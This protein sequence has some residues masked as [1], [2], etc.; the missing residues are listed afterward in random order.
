MRTLQNTFK[1]VLAAFSFF[2]RLPFW[3]IA[4]IEKKHYERVVPLWSLVGWLTGG[5]M[6]VVYIAASACHLPISI[7]VLLSLISRVLVTGALHEDGFADFCDGFGGGRNRQRILEIMKDSH[8]GTYGVLGLVF[9]YLL[10]WN[11]MTEVFGAGTSPL[12]FVAVDAVCKYFSSTIIYFLPYARTE[13]EAKNKLVY[14]HTSIGKKI[15]SFV[16]GFLPISMFLATEPVLAFCLFAP[17]ICCALL[18]RW[19]HHRIQGYTGDCC[20][21]TFIITESIFYLSLCV[22]LFLK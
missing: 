3:R 21:A 11:V 4:D 14:A 9:Y 15:L 16:F 5:I 22:L 1:R 10:L 18:F 12:I 6:A 8:I 2:T 17:L 13:A 7:C 20:G 19:M